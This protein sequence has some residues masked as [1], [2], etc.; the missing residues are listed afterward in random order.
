MANTIQADGL[1]ITQ[2]QSDAITAAIHGTTRP[3]AAFTL[4]PGKWQANNIIDYCTTTGT[5]LYEKATAVL[6]H[7]FDHKEG[8]TVTFSFEVKERAEEM[9]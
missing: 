4:T 6:K 9:G 8:C 5:K 3:V 2:S 7:A 1:G